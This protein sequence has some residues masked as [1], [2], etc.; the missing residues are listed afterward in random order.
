MKD[1]TDAPFAYDGLD[2]VLHER[3]RLS[4]MASLAAQKKGLSFAELKRLCDLSDG[5]LSRHL[6][7]LE[8]HGFVDIVKGYVGRRPSTSCSMTSKGRKAFSQYIDVLEQVVK[9]ASRVPSGKA[10]RSA[11]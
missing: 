10:K 1:K 3:A 7:V 8:E 6:Q 11:G 5:N 2:R 9:D 4:I